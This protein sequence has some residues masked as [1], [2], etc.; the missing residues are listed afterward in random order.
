MLVNMGNSS[1]SYMHIY[2]ID[3]YSLI[4]SLKLISITWVFG[5]SSEDIF[6]LDQNMNGKLIS[7]VYSKFIFMTL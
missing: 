6:Q 1:S 4:I 2:I 3:N 5:I 7:L